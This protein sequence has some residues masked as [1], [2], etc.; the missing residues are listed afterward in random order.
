MVISQ[1][2][3]RTMF[4]LSRIATPA[5]TASPASKK[6][7]TVSSITRHAPGKCLRTIDPTSRLRL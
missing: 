7:I 3:I 6:N 5:T 1:Y 2:A 4:V